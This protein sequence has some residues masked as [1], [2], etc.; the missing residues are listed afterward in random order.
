MSSLLSAIE[1]L[2]QEVAKRYDFTYFKKKI[3][4]YDILE[5]EMSE[6]FLY[7]SLRVEKR[8]IQIRLYYNRIKELCKREMWEFEAAKERVLLHEFFHILEYEKKIDF[9]SVMVRRWGIKKL[10]PQVIEEIAHRYVE[11]VIEKTEVI[12]VEKSKN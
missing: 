9:S 4:E 3:G 5:I 8:K 11:C 12:L 6:S 7:G 1:R 2:A 10:L